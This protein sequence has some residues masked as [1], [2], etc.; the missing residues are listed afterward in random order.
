IG[1]ALGGA[2][3]GHLERRELLEQA[4]TVFLDA[5]ELGGGDAGREAAVECAPQHSRHL[6]PAFARLL[7]EVLEREDER[8]Q[9]WI[10][11]CRRALRAAAAVVDEQG[12]DDAGGDEGRGGDD[13]DKRSTASR[14]LRRQ[15]RF[16]PSCRE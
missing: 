5:V 11:V 1:G 16:A 13:E 2:V 3:I 7:E 12:R 10:R 15:R 4:L 14:R 9:L 8:P 6:D